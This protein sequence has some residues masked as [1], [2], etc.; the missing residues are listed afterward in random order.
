MIYRKNNIIARM[1]AKLR[2]AAK[3]RSLGCRCEGCARFDFCREQEQANEN[4][5]ALKLAAEKAAKEKAEAE[6][7]AAAEKAAK[8]KAEAEAKAAAEK[9]AKEK[10]EA[11]AKAAAEKAAKEKAE[12]EAKAAAEKEAKEKAEAEAKAAAEKAA[13][14]KAEAEA[15]AEAEKAAK[16]KAEAEAKAAAEK[17]AKE[18]AEAEAKAAKEKAAKEKAEAE[19]KAAAEKAAKE[20]VEAEAKAAAEKEAKEKAEAEAKAAAEKAAKEKAEAEAKAAAEKAA[21]EKA[22]AKAEAEKAAKEKA[23][24]ETAQTATEET[25]AEET[26]EE[27]PAEVPVEK[28]FK[29]DPKA[30]AAVL[31]SIATKRGRKLIYAPKEA[32]YEVTGIK[33]DVEGKKN[34]A[35]VKV[36]DILEAEIKEGLKL[37]Y[38]EKYDGLKTS[39]IKEE[40]E[41]D[42]V[43]EL[44]EQ[45][46]KKMGLLLDGDKVKVYLFDWTGSGCHHVGYLPE[47]KAAEIR[48]YLEKM[49]EYSFDVLGIITGGKSKTVTKDEKTGKITITKGKDGNYGVDLDVTVIK[50]KD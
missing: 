25:V 7:K 5:L 21:K 9:A 33:I 16:E 29:L 8:E 20:K 6:A 28:G 26:A 34:D 2:K 42:T 49:D 46:F 19:A 48:P 17:A 47:D 10:A 45:E 41:N 1:R 11:E 50:R 22:E 13:K 27:K 40:Y 18:K 14:E 38:L 37:G 4:D 32:L 39:E 31:P 43:W 23:E 3:C 30:N 24:A 12:A 44:A 35:G 15:K 36:K